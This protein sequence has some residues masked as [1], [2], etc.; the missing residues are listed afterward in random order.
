MPI[1]A[2]TSGAAARNMHAAAAVT[3]TG[4]GLRH[5]S[6]ITAA[7]GTPQPAKKTAVKFVRIRGTGQVAYLD[8]C[9]AVVVAKPPQVGAGDPPHRGRDV[10]RGADVVDDQDDQGRI[11]RPGIESVQADQETRDDRSC[12][13][14][15]QHE[16][17]GGVPR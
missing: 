14:A 6:A 3:A 9:K 13:Q 10:Y 16:E 4:S 15:H 2:K 11:S 1:P 8:F 5:I 12:G 17:H 7:G